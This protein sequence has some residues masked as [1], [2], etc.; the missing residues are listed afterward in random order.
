MPDEKEQPKPLQKVENIDAGKA[1][2]WR[3]G[4]GKHLREGVKPSAP[5][6]FSLPKPVD[7]PPPPVASDAKN[8]DKK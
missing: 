7:I 2:S 8:Q 3:D 5:A 6:N 1:V 4:E